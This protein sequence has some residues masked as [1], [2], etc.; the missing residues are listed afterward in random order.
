[1]IPPVSL[2]LA[3]WVRDYEGGLTGTRYLGDPDGTDARGG[4]NRWVALFAAACRRAVDDAWS[5]EERV[6]VLQA[7]WRT[8]L[9][10]V[11]RGSALELL[12]DALP[13]VPVFTVGRGAELVG[14]SFQATNEAMAR[15]MAAGILRP[16][17]VGRRNRAFEA[18]EVIAAFTDLERRLASPVGDTRLAPPA[19]PVPGRRGSTA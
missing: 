10:S 8:R 14:R 19:R 13:G 7:R 4:L 16:I 9:G 11:R 3:T 12:L 2:V 6:G 15:L 18:S 1:V 17:R 5:Y